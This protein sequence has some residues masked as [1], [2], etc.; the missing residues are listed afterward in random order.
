[1]GDSVLFLKPEVRSSRSYSMTALSR[2]D[3]RRDSCEVREKGYGIEDV[4]VRDEGKVVRKR[5]S[6][7]S[8]SQT[9]L[10]APGVRNCGTSLTA[11]REEAS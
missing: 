9:S 4:G 10:V 7:N 11:I 3:R 1:M 2:R 6:G 5:G 8:T